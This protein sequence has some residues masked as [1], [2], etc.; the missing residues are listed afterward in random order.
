MTTAKRRAALH[1][2]AWALRTPDPAATLRE[3]LDAL[4]VRPARRPRPPRD[5][6]TALRP[7][8]DADLYRRVRA[9]YRSG[10]GVDEIAADIGRTRR[11]TERLIAGQLAGP[12][13]PGQPD[14]RPPS[15]G[16]GYIAD[17][18]ARAAWVAAHA[19]DYVTPINTEQQ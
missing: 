10:T 16:G 14:P 15:T 11:A 3:L 4:G 9:A 19:P 13:R 7:P 18:A 5:F 6:E 2:A 12:L 1:A 17:P 8:I